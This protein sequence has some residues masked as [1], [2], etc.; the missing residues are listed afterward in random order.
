MS[1]KY[2]ISDQFAPHSLTMTIVDWIDVFSRSN[3]KLA[4]IDSLKFCQEYKSLSILGFVIMSNHIHMICKADGCIGLSDI[5]RDFKTYTSKNIIKLIQNEHESQREWMLRAFSK[6]RAHLKKGFKYKVWQNRNQA[7]EIVSH[8]F[9]L[10][11][12]NYIHSNPVKEM[13]VA[14]QEDYIFSSARNYADLDSYIDVE[15]NV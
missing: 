10:E 2:L 9:F 15:M 3:Q 5:I 4:I 1:D 14:N 6:A 7:K 13:I 12:L 11:K 8:N